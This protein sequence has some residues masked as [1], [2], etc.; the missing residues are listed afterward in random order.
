MKSLLA[1]LHKRCPQTVPR[2]MQALKGKLSN[3]RKTKTTGVLC[4]DYAEWINRADGGRIDAQKGKSFRTKQRN[5]LAKGTGKKL[6]PGDKAVVSTSE[7]SGQG[8][9]S[10][11]DDF[12]EVPFTGV[13]GAG[14]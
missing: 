5:E 2:K 6:T 9:D 8:T 11:D 1:A 10:D 7:D 4:H 13:G 12:A 14:K 3:M